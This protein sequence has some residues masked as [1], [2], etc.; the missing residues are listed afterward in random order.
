MGHVFLMQPK[1]VL[2]SLADP[3]PVRFHRVDEQQIDPE[4]D[5]EPGPERQCDYGIQHDDTPQF[6]PTKSTACSESASRT[7]RQAAAPRW[8]PI[9]PGTP[10]GSRWQK[11]PLSHPFIVQARLLEFK[12][13]VHADRVPFHPRDLRDSNDLPQPAGQPRDLDHDVDRRGDLATDDP[14][15]QIEPRHADHHLQAARS[16]PGN[17]WHG[18]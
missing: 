17:C 4:Y 5:E 3:H 18:S 8:P 9:W 6:S 12:Q 15:R 11:V 14:N 13:V 16:R 10:A 7:T 2:E 1:F